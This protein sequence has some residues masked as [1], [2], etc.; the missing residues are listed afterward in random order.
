MKS[1]RNEEFV[2]QAVLNGDL[3]IKPDGTIWRIRKRGWDRWKKKAVS[4]PCKPVRAENNVGE[5]LQI[6]AMLDGVRV[7]ALAHRLVYRH[8]KGPIL[9][10]LTVNHEDGK[11][12]NNHPSNLELATYSEQQIHALHVLKVGR[13]DQNG[14]KNAMV[15]LTTCQVTEIRQ[16]RSSGEKLLSIADDYG[17]TFQTISKIARGDRRLIR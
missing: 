6:R 12:K 1:K 9:G 14:E 2:Y 4:R 15:K 13:I 8:F 3:I 17:V 7:Y 10:D 16:R 11:K 5:Y